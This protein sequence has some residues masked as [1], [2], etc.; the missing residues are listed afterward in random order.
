MAEFLHDLN[1][2]GA[3][4]IQFKTAAG[5]N[6]G[7]IDQNGNNLVLTNAVG[8]ILLGDGAADVYIGD[9][10][11][12]VDILFEQSGNIKADD[13]AS[14]VT[15]TLGSS[16]TTLNLVSPNITGSLTLPATTINNKLTFTTSTGYILF[17][18][19]TSDT[20]EYS[21][22]VALL[23]IDRGGT[24]K[25]ILSR[26]SKE[27][28]LALGADDTVAILAGDTKSVIKANHNFVNENVVFASEGG[29]LAFGFPG[30]DTTWSNRNVFQFRSESSTASD[31]G[32]YLGDGGQTQFIDLSRNLKNIGTISSGAITSTGGITMSGVLDGVTNMFL[33]EYLY[34]Q[35]DGDTYLNFQ[36][37]NE[38]RIVIGG[39]EKIHFNTSRIRINDDLHAAA[40]SSYD[41]GTSSVRFANIY[42][43]TL[44]GDG[45]NITGVTA[46][47]STKLPLAGGTMTGD[48]DMN[49]EML[50][51]HNG[52]P[53]LPQFRGKRSNTDLDD[54]DWD[55]EGGWS[56]TT[57]ENNTTNK[58]S[59]GLHNGNGLLSFNTHG[60]DGTNNYMH[61]IALTTQTDKLWHRR[62]NGT[63]WGNW[64]EIKKG[65]I[66]FASLTSKPTTISGY[67]I[68]DAYTKT[69]ADARYVL[70]T[71][72]S[73]SAMTGDLHIIAGAP[74]IVLQDNTD[75]DDH[76]IVFRNNA[77]GDD[78]KITTQ[79]FTSAATGDGL[80]IGSESSDPVKLV[81]NDT[82]ALTI[83]SGQDALFASDVAITAKLA[84]G[85]TSAHAS[86][87]LYNQGTFY[88]NGAATINANL[89][90]DAGSISIS[91]DGANA[92][93]LTESGSGD[94]TID[95]ADDIRLDAGGGDIVLRANGSEYGRL[96]ND[97]Q[98]LVIKNITEDKDISFQG[99]DGNGTSGVN[100]TALK[101]DMSAAGEGIF[102]NNIR[103]PGEITQAGSTTFSI[104]L[105]DHSNYTWLRNEPGQWSFQSGTSGDDW[106]QSWQ[107]Y[108]PNVGSDG[109]NATFVELGQRHTNDTTGEFKGVKIVKRT[110]SGVVDGDFQAGATTVSDLTVTGNLSI[111]G[112][113]NSYN[114]TDLDVTD[115]TITVGVGQTAANSGSSGLIIDRSDSTNPSMLWNQSD[116]RFEFNS[117]VTVTGQLRTT[118][119]VYAKGELYVQ[120][121]DSTN[122]HV[123]AR[124]NGTEGFLTVNNGSNWGFI[125]RGPSNDPRIGAYYNGTLKIEG[126]H[127]SD[128]STGSNAV[129]FAQ[130]QFGN[131]HFQM[132]AAT[133]T[134]AGN[135]LVDKAGDN[136]S[137]IQLRRDTTSDNT[138]VGDINWLN[139]NAEG[140]DD[141]LAV[142][143]AATQGG[144][145]SNRGGKL[146]FFTRVGS[147]S[148][149]RENSINQFGDWTFYRHLTVSTGTGAGTVKLPVGSSS[150][151][152]LT[153]INNTD[154]GIYSTDGTSVTVAVD[155][156]QR[157]NVHTTGIST[158]T[159]S[160]TTGTF[161]GAVTSNGTT[162]TGD[163]DISGIATNATAISG[164]VAKAGDTMTG[165]LLINH[166]DGLRLADTA[167]ASTSRTTFKSYTSGG[168]SQTLIK[169]GNFIHTVKYETSWNDFN[170]ALLTSSYNTGDS[171][172]RL[173]K[174][175][176]SGGVDSYTE[177][178][179]GASTFAG[180]VTA[181]TTF[182]ADAVD[183]TNSDPGTDNARY[184]GYGMIGNRGNLYVTNFNSSG[185]V[186]I[187]VGGAHNAAPKLSVGTT[188]SIFYT[189][190]GVGGSPGAKLDVNSGTTNTVA[191][192]EST[193]DKAFIRVK[194]NDTDTH[195]ISKDG[196]FSIGDSS[197]DYD[198]F[199]VNISNGNVTVAGTV[200]GVD[201]AA[202]DGVLTSTTTT[203]NAALPK[204]GGTMTG[205]LILNDSKMLKLGNSGAETSIY[206]DGTDT[207]IQQTSGNLYLYQG[208]TNKDIVFY[209]DKDGTDLEIARFDG[210][211]QGLKFKD[212]KKIIMGDSGD[213]QIQSDNSNQLFD[214]YNLSNVIFRQHFLDGDMTFQSDDGSGGVTTYFKLDGGNVNVSVAKNF[215]FQDNVKAEFGNDGDLEI[216]HGNGDSYIQNETGHLYIQNYSNDKNIELQTDNGSGGAIKYF[217]ANGATGEAI[218]YHYGT[219]KLATTSTGIIINNSNSITTDSGRLQVNGAFKATGDIV[220]VD[221]PYVIHTGW[222]DDT[223]TT[224]NKIIPLGNSVTEQNVSAADGQHFFVAPY[225]GSVKKIIMKNVAGTLS[226]GFTTELKLYINGSQSAL[227]GELTASSNA[228]TWEPSSSNTFSAA[229]TISLV[230]QKS[231]SSKYWREVAL[232]MV[233]IMDSQDI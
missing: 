108:V 202:R 26:V 92:V 41:I 14:N 5:A 31:N 162:L 214:F 129:D 87:D 223:S 39:S 164:K 222:G 63:T 193:D 199:K 47:D 135:L 81:T 174:S 68:T 221:I 34:H 27:G 139:S 228:I 76:Q 175:D 163:Q 156:T 140:T 29:F 65:D 201:I 190:L 111:T 116:G 122:N 30:N 4:Q 13:S 9:G 85:A 178:S 196:H 204:A 224:A 105:K 173:N 179:T 107:I 96:S 232:T 187:G 20:G 67:G 149:F 97:S 8:D 72:G 114:V 220:D 219:E 78:Y 144:N 50:T 11:N 110:G 12:N 66:T 6:A 74:K 56:Y 141:R 55:T 176:S 128:G 207:Y 168:N 62:R 101:L 171:K 115:K 37:A 208:A 118:G 159:I 194:D 3:G 103:V 145:T 91:G 230:Y 104:D 169:G 94:F 123:T 195:L 218:L 25:T 226:S 229:D 213:I 148:A 71:G 131:D 180:T 124:S 80:F 227:S 46:T 44:Y 82:I 90:V 182:I 48:I 19:E 181:A 53:E 136:V 186:Q 126:F 17:D 32:L 99:N 143:R 75:D 183:A 154:S 206:S 117:G 153:F 113:I 166:D 158:G 167:N 40:D 215:L 57:F 22:E 212:G 142:I 150:A 84:V 233:L 70:E 98:H 35:G 155:G 36:N 15:L 54:R 127:S 38:F 60:G 147:S 33:G 61:Q 203:A 28:A 93:T 189:N 211:D 79:D 165:Q 69:D 43:D 231:A 102:H 89:T 10:A 210:S 109:G 77:N 24:E 132:N 160:G 216:R 120:D 73:S 217:R 137:H 95:A 172:F 191:I 83:D 152:S 184:S 200:D 45:S 49:D 106:T 23:K 177:I 138:T 185:T 161:T 151:P 170:Y 1:I 21:S 188:N 119:A 2:H 59:T 197:S 42:A 130:F 125:V 52:N 225:A 209:C 86:Y 198:N 7:K 18:Y 58:P 134:F 133:S 51:Y 64:E 100:I 121:T 192:F 146:S 157:L 205:H 16:N 88:S 112:D